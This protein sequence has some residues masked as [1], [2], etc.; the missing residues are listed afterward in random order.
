MVC[1]GISGVVNS[2]PLDNTFSIIKGGL[3]TQTYFRHFSP[4]EI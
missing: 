4:P 3:R 2:L 1:Y